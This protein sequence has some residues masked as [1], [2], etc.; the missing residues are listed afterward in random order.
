MSNL[1]PKAKQRAGTS[2][3]NWVAG[4]IK[5]QLIDLAN[6]TYDGA[7]EFF[8]EIPVNARVGPA[9]SLTAK[10]CI[11]GVFDADD[12]SIVGL[13]NAPTIEAVVIYCDTGNETT[14]Y[15][16]DFINTGSGLPSAANQT[17][18]DITWSNGVNK[19]FAL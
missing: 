2:G 18:V 6:Y 1:Y 13:V 9:T 19:I 8:V 7:H 10:T 4:N 15:L 16:I 14:S 17:Q 11:N 12:L 3:L 5:V